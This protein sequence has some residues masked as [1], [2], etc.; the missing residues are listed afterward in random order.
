MLDQRQF[1]RLHFRVSHELA[2]LTLSLQMVETWS[3]LQVA[4]LSAQLSG[5]RTLARKSFIHKLCD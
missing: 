3:F 4:K 2:S 5:V 1:N